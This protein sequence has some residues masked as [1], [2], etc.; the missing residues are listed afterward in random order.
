M[1]Q[2]L[3]RNPVSGHAGASQFPG[4]IGAVENHEVIMGGTVVEPVD[5]NAAAW[6]PATAEESSDRQ[7][8][9]TIAPQPF[10][11]RYFR[12]RPGDTAMGWF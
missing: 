5:G 7:P 4:W 8:L 6:R 9:A 3:P 2:I 12:N 11:R 10:E 1:R